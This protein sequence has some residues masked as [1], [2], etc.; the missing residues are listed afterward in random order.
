MKTLTIFYLKSYPAARYGK[1]YFGVNVEQNPT[2]LYT[3]SRWE[4]FFCENEFLS[5]ANSFQK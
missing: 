2:Y 1:Y 3:W 5:I 4:F